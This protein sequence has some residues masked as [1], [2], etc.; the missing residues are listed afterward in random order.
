M[1][2]R[3]ALSGLSHGIC[4]NQLCGNYGLKLRSLFV[5]V[6]P[7][8]L[9]IDKILNPYFSIGAQNELFFLRE[10]VALGVFNA[11][12]ESLFKEVSLSPA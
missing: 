3:A 1:Q 11:V 4:N 8:R 9:F 12:L 5:V 6:P 7:K 2:S 10:F